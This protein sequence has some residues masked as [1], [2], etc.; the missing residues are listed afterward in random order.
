[1]SDEEFERLCV[2][3]DNVLIQLMLMT[4]KPLMTS[5]V[6]LGRMYRLCRNIEY[7]EEFIR[8][9]EFAINKYKIDKNDEETLKEYLTGK[10]EKTWT[11]PGKKFGNDKK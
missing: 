11:G 9:C 10:K 4:G 3:I 2:V 5:S 7:S 1:M 8:I 6:I